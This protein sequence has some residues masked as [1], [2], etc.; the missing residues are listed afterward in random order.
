[1]KP[2]VEITGAQVG[3]HQ[4]DAGH[5]RTLLSGL[6]NILA[7]HAKLLFDVRL[8]LLDGRLR[9]G[10]LGLRLREI[11]RHLGV[12]LLGGN[13]IRISPCLRRLGVGEPHLRVPEGLAGRIERTRITENVAIGSLNLV[14]EGLCLVI[15]IVCGRRGRPHGDAQRA[16]QQTRCQHLQTPPHPT[17]VP[18]PHVNGLAEMLPGHGRPPAVVCA[19]CANTSSSLSAWE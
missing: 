9:S 18:G 16:R 5:R 11:R 15:E 7:D 3:E 13:E 14:L 19:T 12:H 4:A 1:L 8:S 6:A 17:I 10:Q 2:V